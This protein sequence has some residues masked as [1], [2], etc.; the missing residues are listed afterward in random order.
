MPMQVM[1]FP[2]FM[3]SNLAR[4][5]DGKVVYWNGLAAQALAFGQLRLAANGID[6]GQPDGQELE[7]GG[8]VVQ[9]PWPAVVAQ[10][11]Q[12]LGGAWAFQTIN[13]DFRK[14]IFAQAQIQA[15]TIKANFTP[16][17]PV[18]LVGH[19]EGGVLA[20]AVWIN[21]ALSS[22][23][24]LIRRIVA[25]GAPFQGSYA[26]VQGLAGTLPMIQQFVQVAGLLGLAATLG[27]SN[28]FN[29]VYGVI[30]TW[31][32][33]YELYPFLGTPYAVKDTFRGNLYF[34][35]NYG[36]TVPPVQAWLDFAKDSWQEALW[37]PALFPPQD[38]MTSIYSVG[39]STPY[40]LANGK[41][42]LPLGDPLNPGSLLAANDGDGYVSSASAILPGSDTFQMSADHA[43]MPLAAAQDG[44]LAYAIQKANTPPIP[45]DPP[46]FSGPPIAKG[47]NITPA[48]VNSPVTGLVCIGGG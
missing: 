48:P 31:P 47:Q 18:T 11:Q 6:P 39:I 25:I 33:I 43:S 46:E 23:T 26:A 24:S 17:N 15:Q 10:L 3:A 14:D 7:E 35:A 28:V 4:V 22:Q 27:A 37:Q 8:S 41:V 44:L 13:W 21:L 29:F 36:W 45:P 9:D 20:L 42:P 16:T 19:S 30:R 38:V 1:L 5:S 34:A 40:A 2:G 12:Q 32:A